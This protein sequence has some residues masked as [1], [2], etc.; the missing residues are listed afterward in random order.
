M[1]A[2][3]FTLFLELISYHSFAGVSM[4][5]DQM[6]KLENPALR[7]YLGLDGSQHGVVVTSPS[8]KDKSELLEWDVLTEIMGQPVDDEGNVPF[9]RFRVNFGSS[10]HILPVDQA[11]AS[12]IRAGQVRRVETP[13]IRRRQMLIPDLQGSAPSY[14]VF[15]PMVFSTATAQLIAVISTSEQLEGMLTFKGSPL[16]RRRI[17]TP[18]FPDEQLVVIPCPYFP[19]RLTRGYDDPTFNV[20]KAVNGK[21]VRNLLHLVQLLRAMK[22]DFVTIEFFEKSS[23]L[24]VFSRVEM[25]AATEGVLNDNNIRSQGST[26]VMAVW[27]AK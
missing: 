27:N 23:E 13:V 5:Y 1:P 17:D 22:D 15:G 21:P 4:L 14:F 3:E 6:Q 16:V 24:L 18:S 9:G 25:I 8:A 11:R 26:D 10:L 2:T 19:H 12:V 20:V 7:E